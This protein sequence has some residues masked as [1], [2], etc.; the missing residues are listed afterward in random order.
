MQRK[1]RPILGRPFR[2]MGG[3]GLGAEEGAGAGD[4]GGVV[5]VDDF[6]DD[7]GAEALAVGDEGAL[8]VAHA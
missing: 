3:A 4:V 6:V 1:G 7:V 8:V 2:C 5:Y